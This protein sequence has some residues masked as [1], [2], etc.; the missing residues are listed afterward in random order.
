MQISKQF[1]FIIGGAGAAGCVIARRILDETNAT[2]LLLEAGDGDPSSDV[3]TDPNKWFMTFG[4]DIDYRYSYAPQPFLNNRVIQAP[5]GKILGGSSSING[6]IW[7]RGNRSD[8][9]GW[10]AQGND[11]WDYESVVPLFKRIEDWEGGESDYH[12]SGGPVHIEKVKAPNY[13]AT[14]LIDAAVSFGLPLMDDMSGP[15]PFGAGVL[16]RNV[17]EGKRSSAYTGYLQPVKHHPNLTLLTG[18]TVVRLIL[19]GTTC[20]GVQYIREGKTYEA[21]ADSEVI[22]CAG[23]FDSPRILMLSGI[24]EADE[25]VGVG[26]SPALLLKGVGKNLQDHANCAIMPVLKPEFVTAGLD[27]QISMVFAKSRHAGAASNLMFFDPPFPLITPEVA[28]RYGVPGN[29][30]S[31]ISA[32]MLPE[33]RGYVKMLSSSPLGPLEIQP[34]MLMQGS[35]LMTMIEGI[36]MALAFTDQPAMKDMI[37]QVVGLSS[38]STD[39]KIVEYIKL[40]MATYFHPTGTCKMGSDENSVVDEKLRVHGIERLRVADASIMPQITSGNTHAPTLMIGEKLAADL[41]SEPYLTKSKAFAT[42]F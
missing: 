36:R 1:D 9:E 12:G 26:I 8:Y 30:F 6:L 31:I 13:L 33:T 39:E 15:D 40:G 35:D 3:V 29:T 34:N 7:A 32:L 23:T 38:Q 18:A 24:G 21:Y 19:E 5:R 20:K 28:G 42:S 17:K 37:R 25:L 41:L 27:L 22:L 16:V 14:A 4:T 11:G 10:A 2:V